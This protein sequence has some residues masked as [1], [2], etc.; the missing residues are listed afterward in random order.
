MRSI[1]NTT[2][3]EHRI[4]GT[5]KNSTSQ[6]QYASKGKDA[7]YI[8]DGGCENTTAMKSTAIKSTS[9]SSSLMISAYFSLKISQN[10]TYY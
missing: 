5:I 9:K 10:L 3:I 7:V 4:F 6:E 1:Q 2:L 8:E